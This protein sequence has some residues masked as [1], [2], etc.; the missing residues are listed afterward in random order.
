VDGW[1]KLFYI[2]SI[3]ILGLV[4]TFAEIKFLLFTVLFIIL[5]GFLLDKKYAIDFNY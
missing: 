2:S 1:G 5:L 3:T 4:Y